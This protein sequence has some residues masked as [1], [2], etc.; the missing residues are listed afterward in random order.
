[1]QGIAQAKAQ[2]KYKERRKDMEKR[3]IIA[4]LLKSGLRYSTDSK[5]FKAINF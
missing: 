4:S 2:G 5:I 1:M 3:R